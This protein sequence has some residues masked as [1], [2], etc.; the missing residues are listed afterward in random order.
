MRTPF[1]QVGATRALAIVCLGL[2]LVAGLFL[3]ARLN[4]DPAAD[5]A[6]AE[7]RNVTELAS[8]LWANVPGRDFSSLSTRQALEARLI[9]APMLRHSGPPVRSAWGTE[10]EVLPYKVA[11]EGDALMVRYKDLPPSACNSLIVELAPSLYDIQVHRRSV[12]AGGRAV[13]SDVSSA[14]QGASTTV[15]FIYQ[16]E[17]IPGT[18]MARSR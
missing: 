2:V 3:H 5:L 18:A 17:F 6:R 11:Q 8:A 14:C 1:R 10:V 15:D 7:A 12:M 13:G 4:K 16:P 9:P